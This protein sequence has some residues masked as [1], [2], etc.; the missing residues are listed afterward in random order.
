MSQA[1]VILSDNPT[2]HL[3]GAHQTFWKSKAPE[4]VLSGPYE[5]GKTL[6]ALL[7]VH[8]LLLKYDKC[9]I[10]MVRK[11]YKSLITSAVVTWEQKIHHGH[12]GLPDY[13]ITKYGGERPDWY[14]YPNGSRL[15]LGGMDNPDKFL[16]SEF[17]FIYVNQVEELMLDDWEKLTGRATG[18]AGNSPYTQVMGDCNPDVPQHW[19]LHRKRLFMIETRHEDNPA[20]YD[21]QRRT[22]TAQGLK[23]LEVLDGLTGVRYKRGRLGLWVGREGQVYDFDPAVHLIDR[24]DIPNSWKRYAAVDFGYTNPFTYQWYAEDGD[25]RLYLYREIYMSQRTV[26]AH[27][28]QIKQ[29]SEPVQV[30][31]ADHDAEDRATLHE[32]GIKTIA[33]DKRVSVGIEKVQERLKIQGDGR[34]RLFIMRDS[35]VEEDPS[36]NGEDVRRPNCTEQE[37]PGYVWPTTKADRAADEKPV[38]VDDHGIDAMRYMV[39]YFD[40]RTIYPD[41]KVVKYA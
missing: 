28:E 15:I 25:G 40:G 30:T 4:A 37:F 13:S 41:P 31:V 24:F 5:T 1:A 35:L 12:I 3:Q 2:Y 36:L 8:G 14:D 20:L 27:A 6:A 29:F 16:S 10:L 39:M 11:T 19:I 38:K 32:H 26:R 9:R 22:W 21:E 34:P 7:K 33:A 23:T 18:R 17:D